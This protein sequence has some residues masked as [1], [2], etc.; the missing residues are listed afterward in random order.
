MGA[1]FISAKGGFPSFKYVGMRL[2]R[3][4][5]RRILGLIRKDFKT[6]GYQQR[7]MMFHKCMII[8]TII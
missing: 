6:P 8:Y 3:Q 1:R 4:L 2:V 5:Y 7:I